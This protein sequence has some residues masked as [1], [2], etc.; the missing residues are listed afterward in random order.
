MRKSFLRDTSV[1][2]KPPGLSFQCLVGLDWPPTYWLALPPSLKRWQTATF[3]TRRFGHIWVF[4]KIG[5]PQN[6]WFIMED[7]GGTTSFGNTHINSQETLLEDHGG[8]LLRFCG[9]FWDYLDFDTLLVTVTLC[10]TRKKANCNRPKQRYNGMW[11][12]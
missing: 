11:C 5:V 4:P 9:I 2:S 7:L 12:S 10:L 3:S 8:F 1:I 6:G